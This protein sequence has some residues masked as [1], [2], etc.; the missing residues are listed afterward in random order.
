MW[1]EKMKVLSS[2][3]ARKTEVREGWMDRRGTG[4]R[5]AQGEAPDENPVWFS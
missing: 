2:P 5:N 3:I 1:L 4:V